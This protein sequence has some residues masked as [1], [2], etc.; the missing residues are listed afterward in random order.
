M[1]SANGTVRLS[2][3][4][5]QRAA[6]G[7]GHGNEDAHKNSRLTLGPDDRPQDDGLEP[8]DLA[9][10]AAIHYRDRNQAIPTDHREPAET[11]SRHE[12]CMGTTG[13]A[14]Q[15]V[16]ARKA[17]LSTLDPAALSYSV[18]RDGSVLVGGPCRKVRA[19]YCLDIYGVTNMPTGQEIWFGVRGEDAM[20]TC[21]QLFGTKF[22]SEATFL[23]DLEGGFDPHE[24]IDAHNEKLDA[25]YPEALRA[26]GLAPV[27]ADGDYLVTKTPMGNRKMSCWDLA[28]QYDPYEVG[29]T[30]ATIGVALSGRYFPT[31]LDWRD[32]HG[33]LM[34]APDLREIIAEADKVIPIIQRELPF[35][36]DWKLLLLDIFY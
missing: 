28:I 31:L 36:K 30:H 26:I 25:C 34:E 27:K 13:E 24:D 6:R 11:T 21:N 16:P 7:T 10:G 20:R 32:P 9:D 17:G 5:R 22:Q 18:E 2:T 33:T 1:L 14:S 23:A 15:S 4:S 35:T 8:P 19:A 3:D 29:D 12:S